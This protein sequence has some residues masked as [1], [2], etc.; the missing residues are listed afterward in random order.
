MNYWS[1][2]L[3]VSQHDDTYNNMSLLTH[4][5]DDATAGLYPTHEELD[6]SSVLSVKGATYVLF[7]QY[8]VEFY[9]DR[10]EQWHS[11]YLTIIKDH[12]IKTDFFSS[13]FQVI[14]NW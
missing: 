3:D 12:K 9:N 1:K 7:L 8:K 13:F 2:S 14:A 11:V 6:S 5:G 4:R 10:R